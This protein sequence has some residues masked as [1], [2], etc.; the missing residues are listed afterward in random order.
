VIDAQQEQFLEIGTNDSTIYQF[1]P[2]AYKIE[3]D[4]LHGT[5][6]LMIVRDSKPVSYKGKIAINEI[7]Y[8]KLKEESGM[9]IGIVGLI[10][11]IA[12]I[13]I[14]GTLIAKNIE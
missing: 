1:P 11:V 9:P 3:N 8:Y 5:R 13:L 12:G 4:T 14:I 2:K 6:G 10:A 7:E